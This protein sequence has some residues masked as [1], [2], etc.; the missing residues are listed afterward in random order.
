MTTPSLSTTAR[1]S[2]IEKLS[3]HSAWKSS[4]S[5]KHPAI[6]RQL[7]RIRD[8]E[9]GRLRDGLQDWQETDFAALDEAWRC[10]AGHKVTPAIRRAWTERPRGHSKTTDMAIQAAWVL[11]AAESPLRG[12]AAAAD[13]DQAGL[14]RA[15]IRDLVHR[16]PDLCGDLEV[17]LHMVR[18]TQTGAHLEI[19]ASDVRSSWGQLPDFVICDELC[20]WA[21]PDLWYSLLS[22]AAKKS[23]C[24]LAVLTNAGIG[25]G[26]Q[27][28][29]REAARTSPDWHF[30][31]LQGSQAPWISDKD[32]AEQARLLPKPVFD[33]LWRNL[34]QHSDGEFV[35]LAE[36]EACRDSSLVEQSAGRPGRQYF[37]ALDY[38]EK[39]DR[40]VGV[41]L[42]RE[43][44]RLIVDRMDVIDPA[45]ERP[46]PVRWVRDWM[47]RIAAT[48]WQVRFVL[49]DYQLLGVLQE[50]QGQYDVARFDF[51]GGKGNHALALQLRNLIV[52]RHVAWYPGCG[53]LDGVHRDDLETELASLLLTTTAGGRI[54][55]NHRNEPHCHDDRAFALGVACL[56]A[57]QH[58]PTGDWL[59]ITPPTSDGGLLWP[60]A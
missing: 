56:E 39:H 10:L 44:E 22:S 11:Q 42:H 35:T 33:R 17:Q 60:S 41:I 12:I 30:S 23:T 20:H 53:A 45:P 47:E 50:L 34:W 32:I 49:D 1:Q 46:T 19:I 5:K 15:A 27:W 55:I 58:S 37:A 31:S 3:A 24:V 21:Q 52:H 7:I 18:N 36:A 26:W 43:G 16:N 14:I 25:R 40:T 54:R 13:R 51:S 2:L 9:Q 38:A 29:I 48:F 28:D 6:F 59:V 8:G 57:L 4:A